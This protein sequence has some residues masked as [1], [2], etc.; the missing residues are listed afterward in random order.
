[1]RSHHRPLCG[2]HRG[3]LKST[4][5]QAAAT[6]C[7]PNRG[8]PGSSSTAANKEKHLELRNS[9][10]VKVI[11]MLV[12]RA[13]IHV[14]TGVMQAGLADKTQT[15]PRLENVN[16]ER[17]AREFCG[18]RRTKTL[19]AGFGLNRKVRFNPKVVFWVSS[20]RV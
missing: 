6:L 9:E 14:T 8:M 13:R 11:V 5:R 4:S 12:N 20:F 3:Q 18:G 1:M 10:F 19:C 15:E 7:H 16:V 17:G 2:G